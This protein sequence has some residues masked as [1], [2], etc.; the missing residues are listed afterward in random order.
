MQ[1]D[2]QARAEPARKRSREDGNLHG[3]MGEH[4]GHDAEEDASKKKA[5]SSAKNK[6]A[7]RSGRESS[8]YECTTC[9]QACSSQS[10]LTRHLRVHSGDKPYTPATSPTR[11]THAARPSRS[12]AHSR[13]TFGCTP[14]TSP[15]RATHAARPSRRP[16]HSRSTFGC[17]P[18]TSP[19]RAT[20]AARPTP[21]HPVSR[22]TCAPVADR[23]HKR[24]QVHS[25]I[26][27]SA[28]S[29]PCFLKFQTLQ[30]QLLARPNSLL[31][32]RFRPVH[33]FLCAL[34]FLACQECREG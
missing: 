23:A 20:H 16:A 7:Q 18:A 5:R 28:F 11:A 15:T 2:M 12:P 14:A 30:N 17:T 27:S 6:Q 33:L 19:T 26:A 10:Q 13:G 21:V 31:H 32:L 34:Q 9:G 22:S 29:L 3:D 1:K 4:G 24:S 8:V 25:Q